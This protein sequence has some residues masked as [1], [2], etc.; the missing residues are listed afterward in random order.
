MKTGLLKRTVSDLTSLPHGTAA[1]RVKGLQQVYML[2]KGERGRHGGAVMTATDRVNALLACAF[3]P[4]SGKSHA[5]NVTRIRRLDLSSAFYNPL[6]SKLSV[7]D[8][9]RCAFQVVERLGVKFD[10]LGIALDS[11]VQSIRSGAFEDWKAGA[12]A[13]VSIDFHGE[14][15]AMLAFDRPQVNVSVM[16]EFT[17]GHPAEHAPIERFVRFNTAVF[18]RLAIDEPT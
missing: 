2:T 3:D 10:D 16:F 4:P 15:R 9:A 1:D 14:H 5:E 7:E 13:S 17:D 6:G 11:I 18:E 8:N 12:Q